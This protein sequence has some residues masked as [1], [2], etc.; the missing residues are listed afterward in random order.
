MSNESYK[1]GDVVT[2]KSGGP[3][4]TVAWVDGNEAYCEWFVESKVT[5]AKFPLTSLEK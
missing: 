1:P 3:A 5:G 4:M 2:L